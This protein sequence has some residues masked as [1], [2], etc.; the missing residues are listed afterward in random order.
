MTLSLLGRAARYPAGLR[1]LGAGLYAWLQPN[2]ELGE[3]NA[4]LVV[5]DGESLLIDTLWDTRLTRRMLDAMRPHTADAPIRRPV[6]TPGDPDHCWGN[7]LLSDAE[8]GATRAGAQ[9]MLG[10]DPARL[11]LSVRAGRC[12]AGLAS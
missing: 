8:I 7:Q 10:E 4:G 12:V 3:S 2:G 5:G 6:N 11:A 9:D 1:D